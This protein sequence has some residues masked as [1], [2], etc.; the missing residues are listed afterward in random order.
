MY[1]LILQKQQ[2]GRHFGDLFPYVVI[3]GRYDLTLKFSWLAQAKKCLIL[4]LTSIGIK[5]RSFGENCGMEW[6]FC[7]SAS[8]PWQ[9]GWCEALIKSVKVCLS[10]IIGSNVMTFAELQTVM[11]EVAYYIDERPV[12]LKKQW[13]KRRKLFVPK[14]LTSWQSVF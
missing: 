1:T 2:H 11:F 10:S 12:G 13:P 8:A 9:D 14:R 5:I 4:M 6:E 7:K 3:H